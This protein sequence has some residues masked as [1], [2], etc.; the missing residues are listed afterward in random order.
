MHE[1]DWYI[2][3]PILAVIVFFL[4]LTTLKAKSGDKKDNLFGC[5]FGLFIIGFVPGIFLFA[6]VGS[7]NWD[8][9]HTEVIKDYSGDVYIET[10]MYL[11]GER[12]GAFDSRY[13]NNKKKESGFYEQGEKVGLWV[14]WYKNDTKASQ[15]DY[16]KYAPYRL[17]TEWHENGQISRKEYHNHEGETIWHLGENWYENGQKSLEGDAGKYTNG[18][19][20]EWYRNGQIRKIETWGDGKLLSIE[21]YYEDGSPCKY[22]TYKNGEGVVADYGYLGMDELGRLIFYEDYQVVKILDDQTGR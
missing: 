6:C 20:K 7:I 2:Y 3:G 19:E 8:G 10:T 17:V 9:E 14:S 16:S 12:H 18:T 21:Q 4:I 22:T 15:T 13:K 11:D 1:K 5:L